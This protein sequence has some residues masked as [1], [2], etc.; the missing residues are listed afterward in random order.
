MSAG[1]VVPAGMED[2]RRGNVG[3]PVGGLARTKPAAREGQAGLA[4]WRMGPYC[5]LG[6]AQIMWVQVPL[7]LG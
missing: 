7:A 5:V 1:V 2:E 6:S 3:S 4:G